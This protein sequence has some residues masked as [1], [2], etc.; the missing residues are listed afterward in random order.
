MG[1]EV[2]FQKL[3]F[4]TKF[5]RNRSSGGKSGPRAY[6]YTPH[7]AIGRSHLHPAVF[8]VPILTHTGETDTESSEF[9]AVNSRIINNILKLLWWNI[10]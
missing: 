4:S 2:L 8:S 5:A 1:A 3:L 7:Y 9:L 6:L 10:V